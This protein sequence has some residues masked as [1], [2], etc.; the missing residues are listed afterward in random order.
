M[1]PNAVD[2]RSLGCPAIYKSGKLDLPYVIHGQAGSFPLTNSRLAEFAF[3][4]LE[5]RLDFLRTR[6]VLDACAA[7]LR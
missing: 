4:R 6:V 2:T 5:F 7:A 1:R 3:E